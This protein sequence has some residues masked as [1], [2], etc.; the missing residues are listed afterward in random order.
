M[1]TLS[2]RHH[3]TSQQQPAQQTPPKKQQQS[4]KTSQG[5]DTRNGDADHEKPGKGKITTSTPTSRQSEQ[6]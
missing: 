6:S 4:E 3:F 1:F 5:Q 2:N